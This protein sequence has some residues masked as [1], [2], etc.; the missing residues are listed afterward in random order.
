[1]K[2]QFFLI[3]LT[4][5]S[6]SHCSFLSSKSSEPFEKTF[7]FRKV[8]LSLASGNQQSN[9]TL[10]MG[11]HHR[12]GFLFRLTGKQLKRDSMNF[13]R[14]ACFLKKNR[15]V[16][17]EYI[18][19]LDFRLVD[20]CTFKTEEGGLYEGHNLVFSLKSHEGAKVQT[21][22]Q[23]GVA[24]R[25]KNKKFCSGM[26]LAS[27]GK[28]MT[29]TCK[30]RHDSLKAD[31]KGFSDNG[32][33]YYRVT[34]EIRELEAKV[35]DLKK[36][37]LVSEEEHK[38][39][40]A[41]LRKSKLYLRMLRRDVSGAATAYL[42]SK[43]LLREKMSGSLNKGAL[44][45]QIDQEGTFAKQRYNVALRNLDNVKQRILELVPESEKLINRAFFEADH[46]KHREVLNNLRIN[47]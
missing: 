46:G 31:L 37:A 13:F 9:F 12:A 23:V 42:Q 10:L 21:V 44:T 17:N 2:L 41:Q 1:M 36:K 7:G 39:L 33:H 47:P 15:D 29:E 3:C 19:F 43:Q 28:R 5:L 11:L 40:L 20:T 18:A 16:R 22:W 4:I 25:L 45:G 30:S 26:T 34:T 24:P 32:D 35:D 27:F 14:D 38:A 6:L 8:V